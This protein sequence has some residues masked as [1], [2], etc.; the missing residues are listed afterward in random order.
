[1]DLGKLLPGGGSYLATVRPTKLVAGARPIA[2]PSDSEAGKPS[3]AL[4]RPARA[5]SLAAHARALIEG[6]AVRV[7]VC[8]FRAMPAAWRGV[9]DRVVSVEMVEAVGADMYEVRAGLLRGCVWMRECFLGRRTSRRSI[10][11]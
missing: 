1:M 2:F 10:G 3:V 4:V 5:T 6:D 8:D 7:H 9:F 11:R